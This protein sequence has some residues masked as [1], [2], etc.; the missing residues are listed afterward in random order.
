MAILDFGLWISDFP[1]IKTIIVY[2]VQILLVI[3]ICKRYDGL[4]IKKRH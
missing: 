3:V 1:G 2:T 4:F